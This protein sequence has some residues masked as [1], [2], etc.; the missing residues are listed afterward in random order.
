M[1]LA[2]FLKFFLILAFFAFYTNVPAQNPTAP[3]ADSEDTT[4]AI[5]THLPEWENVRR[6]SV[7]I[8]NS[9][10]LK[11]ALGERPVF[12]L[13]NFSAGTEA[14]QANYEAGKLLIVE[15]GN[16]QLSIDAD[17]QIRQ[18][19]TEN[20]PNPPIYARRVGNYEVLVFDA[21]DESSANALIDQVKYEKSVRWL[22]Q[23]P[24]LYQRAERA[25]LEKTANVFTSTILS[26]VLGLTFAVCL[27]IAAGFIVFY[28]RKQKRASMQT[29]SDAGG[30]V[31]LN[32]DD[33]TTEISA[34]RLLKD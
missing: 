32:L 30:M 22:G 20:A 3:A 23:D 31:R 8:T 14:A 33:L 27:G 2:G 7:H 34:D 11:S 21:A 9:E 12:D 24:T 17:N 13:I 6:N 1:Q 18:R 15:Y 29:F 28:M 10:G 19:L 16:P 25:Y 4:P 5:L 26:I